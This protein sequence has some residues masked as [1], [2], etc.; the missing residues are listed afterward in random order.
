MS[1]MAMVH[2]VGRTGRGFRRPECL[3]PMPRPR[4]VRDRCRCRIWRGCRSR[5]NATSVIAVIVVAGDVVAAAKIQP[6]DPVPSMWLRVLVQP[7]PMF[8]PHGSNPCSQSA[9]ACAHHRRLSA[10]C[11]RQ[12]AD[13]AK[14]RREQGCAGIVFGDLAFGMF[15]IEAQADLEHLAVCPRRRDQVGKKAVFL[16]GAVKDHMIA[17]RW[18]ISSGISGVLVGRRR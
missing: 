6:F 2:G 16:F 1:V 5:M 17:D 8:G 9:C 15:G 4:R 18:M 12:L 3:R 14:P 11:G 10:C 7:L 13:T